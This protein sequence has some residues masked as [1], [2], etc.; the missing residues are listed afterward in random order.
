MIIL[1]IEKKAPLEQM[2]PEAKDGRHRDRMKA[3]LL[4][5]EGWDPLSIAQALRL[6]EE[7]VRQHIRA[8]ERNEKL[9][10]AYL[11]T[12][13]NLDQ[14]SELALIQH[15]KSPLYL[16]ME[17]IRA[18]VKEVYGASYS[19]QGMHNGLQRNG[20]SYQK[21]KGT[22]AKADPEKQAVFI[23]AYEDLKRTLPE[24]E[25]ILFG[26]SVHPTMATKVTGGWIRRG[27]E[28]P[29]P[30]TGSRTRLN[31][32]GS[33]NLDGLDMITGE[34]EAI[35]SE[36]ICQHLEAVRARYP[37]APPIH[38][39]LDRAGYHKTEE[40]REKA[41]GL[42]MILHD[43]PPYSPNL[44][45]IERVW[46]VMNEQARNNVHFRSKD[47][48]IQAIRGFFQETW[49]RLA[50]SLIDRINDT[51]QTIREINLG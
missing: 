46:K 44:N 14:M 28:H 45:P 48:F 8:Y 36:A 6:T 33:L 4:A 30:T 7:T 3:V 1:S 21:P 32:V 17:D 51:F 31:I 16:K 25:P 42:G 41:E 26:D 29:I 50:P 18:P 34:F 35:N 10:N 9:T 23:A 43:L 37:K 47:E 12:K 38:Q 20:F 2:H 5:S 27:K 19:H 15:L 49:K 13:P 11:G 40:V 22:P 24:D 39:S